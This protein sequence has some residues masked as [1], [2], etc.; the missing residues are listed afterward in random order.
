M[1]DLDRI[2]AALKLLQGVEDA[3]LYFATTEARRSLHDLADAVEQQAVLERH[4]AAGILI[5]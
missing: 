2:K 4:Q 5:Q 3:E 1:T